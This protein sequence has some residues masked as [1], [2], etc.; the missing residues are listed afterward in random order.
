VL[1]LL[2]YPIAL[3]KLLRAVPLVG[4]ITHAGNNPLP[5]VTAK[6]QDQVCDAV[7]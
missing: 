3:G 5:N 7:D 1:P 2:S 4:C 6:M